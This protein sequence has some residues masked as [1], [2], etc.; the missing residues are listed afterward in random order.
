MPVLVDFK[1][2][3]IDGQRVY[4]KDTD[5]K[6]IPWTIPNVELLAMKNTNSKSLCKEDFKRWKQ[7]TTQNRHTRLAIYGFLRYCV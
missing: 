2:K 7:G 5:G 3:I 6:K 1:H 4:E